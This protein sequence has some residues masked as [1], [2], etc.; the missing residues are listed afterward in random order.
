MSLKK[1]LDLR[2]T[3]A[4]RLAISYAGI[5]TASFFAAIFV[6]YFIMA[7]SLQRIHD[8]DLRK[9]LK[10]MSSLLISNGIDEFKRTLDVESASGGINNIF[11]RII[12]PD[13]RVIYTT[14]MAHWGNIKVSPDA[15]TLLKSGSKHFYETQGALKHEHKARII[16][17]IIGN[18]LILQIGESKKKDE[19]FLERFL[20]GLSVI[21]TLI[22]PFSTYIGWLMGKRA[23]QGVEKVTQTA[24]LISSG[25]LKQRVYVKAG[26][27]EISR[28]ASTFNTM[29]DRIN[30]LVSGIRNMT[31]DIAHDLKK[32][33]S[34]I[35][36]MAEK[37]LNSDNMI[38]HPAVET[39]RILE[40]CDYLMQ[41]INTMLD[42]S[43]AKTGATRLQLRHLDIAAIVRN[44]YEL[45]YPLAEDKSLGFTADLLE[46]CIIQ[47]DIHK[48]QRMIANLIDNA[49]SYTPTGGEVQIQMKENK[50]RVE[51]AVQDTGV[52]ISVEELPHIF[53]RFYRCDKS[54]THSG[55]GLGL[56]L[57]KAIAVSHGGDITAH[58]SLG[59]GSTFTISLPIYQK[60][61]PFLN[62]TF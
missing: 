58:S 57:A 62:P 39:A 9:D 4:F 53:E 10:K 34:R 24:L 61:P 26:N 60:H 21:M 33:I 3:V 35:R 50:D 41:M 11:F 13:G 27:D 7:S 5:F 48:I 16:Y 22:I 46:S 32:P 44:A 36:V 52:G 45:F 43:E 20:Q 54:R 47:G 19:E 8:H 12:T 29:L 25:D 1:I 28:L 51:I 31:D 38:D 23:L 56:T 42:V 59:K 15:L 18:D 37:G 49:L 6:F 40:E 14:D 30:T 55:T 2:L 17:G